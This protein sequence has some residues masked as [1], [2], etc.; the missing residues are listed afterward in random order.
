[1]VFGRRRKTSSLQAQF[2]AKIADQVE[3]AKSDYDKTQMTLQSVD[4]SRVNLRM[5]N[6]KNTLAKNKYLF[7]LAS[8]RKRNAQG[9]L[10]S[11]I[12]KSSKK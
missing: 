11:N 1:M 9:F 8:A 4:S 5:I 10:Q 7:L 2:D 3:K 6:A 12:I